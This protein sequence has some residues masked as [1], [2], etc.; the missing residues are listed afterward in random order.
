MDTIR[1]KIAPNNTLIRPDR[2]KT[3]RENAMLLTEQILSALGIPSDWYQQTY[4]TCL[5]SYLH[6]WF[7]GTTDSS[8]CVLRKSV[9]TDELVVP[10][11]DR[12]SFK[13]ANIDELKRLLDL[14]VEDYA[15]W[16]K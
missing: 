4:H 10:I 5:L 12:D 15:L 16:V 3:Y 2:Q 8:W 9:R 11:S 14:I 1:L 6:D 13:P 7:G